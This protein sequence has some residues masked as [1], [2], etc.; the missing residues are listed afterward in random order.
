MTSIN[1][2]EEETKL[3]WFAVKHILFLNVKTIE[4]WFK[5][6]WNVTKI[7]VKI[8]FEIQQNDF[9]V[10]EEINSSRKKVISGNAESLAYIHYQATITKSVWFGLFFDRPMD[11]KKIS[12]AFPGLCQ[13]EFKIC[14]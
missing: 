7:N 1:I 5:V 11:Q 12:E 3:S 9:K 4:Q 8:L 10:Y 13:M 6:T 14:S 2:G